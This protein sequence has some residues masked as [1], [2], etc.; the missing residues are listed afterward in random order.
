MIDLHSHTTA[1]DGIFSPTKL[2]KKACDENIRTIAIADHDT[3]GGVDEAVAEGK[4]C[5]L[6]VIPAIEFSIDYPHGDFHLLGYYVDCHDANFLSGVAK[7]REARE[8]RIP[9][10]VEHLRASGLDIT[11]S[12]VVEESGGGSLGKPHVARVLVRKKYASSIEDAFDRFLGSGK[13]GDV[14]KEK[15]TAEQGLEMILSAHGIAVCAHPVSL[16]L[17]DSDL[18]KFLGKYIPIGLAGMECYSNMHSDDL[19]KRYCA[20]ADSLSL[21]ITGGSDFHGDKDEALGYYGEKRI[22]PALCAEN[23]ESFR[24]RRS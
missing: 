2:V 6:Q 7:I 13:A 19:V 8:R 11:E 22:V 1:S 20:I 14:P 17:P 18:K 4:K 5:G 16:G 23:L 24:S 21:F 10:I 15:V 3:V 12:E 9:K